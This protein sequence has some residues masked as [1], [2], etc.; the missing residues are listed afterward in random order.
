M[1]KYVAEFIG[2]C[3]LTLFG[4]GAAAVSGGVEGELGV[5]GIA[6][7]F[8][9]AVVAMAFAI[10]DISGCHINPAV[11]L[12]VFVAGGMS[13]GDLIGYII[14]QF[15]GGAAGAGLLYIIEIMTDSVDVSSNGLGANGYGDFSYVGINL[16][17]AILVEIILTFVFVLV[18]LAVISKADNSIIGGVIIG[19]TLTFVHIFGIPLT[20]T[21]VNPAR[22]LGPALFSGVDYI[23]QSW[24]FIVAPLVGA[25]LA[26]VIFKLLYSGSSEE[27]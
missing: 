9:L 20:G 15:L 26:A 17:G 10:G 7:A 18:V 5:L 8:G 25:V 2:T 4:C 14:S 24:V 6:L 23:V 16:G 12:G 13:A 11:S 1:K 27:E 22:S 19:L 3:V 21:S